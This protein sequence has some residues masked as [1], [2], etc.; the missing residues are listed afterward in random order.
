MRRR[1]GKLF[2]SSLRGLMDCLRRKVCFGEAQYVCD[3]DEV[4][5][6]KDSRNLTA[7]DGAWFTVNTI[8]QGTQVPNA[9]GTALLRLWD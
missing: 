1:F 6:Q 2:Y 5:N 7:L 4:D 8:T 3:K 9:A